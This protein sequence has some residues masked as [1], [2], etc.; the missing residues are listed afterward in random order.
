MQ[1]FNKVLEDKAG[2]GC[3][4]TGHLG[5]SRERGGVGTGGHEARWQWGICSQTR[6]APRRVLSDPWV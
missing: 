1:W 2:K 4:Q 6:D 3:G 5:Y